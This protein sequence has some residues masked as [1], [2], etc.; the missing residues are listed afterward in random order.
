MMDG[1]VLHVNHESGVAVHRPGRGASTIPR[2]RPADRGS[3]PRIG[4][5]HDWNRLLSWSLSLVVLVFVGR[6]QEVLPGLSNLPLG[7]IAV[8]LSLIGL[9]QLGYLR[10]AGRI[11][12][13]TQ[14]RTMVSF[15]GI[16]AFTVPFALWPGGA[17]L[18][19]VA[20]L[21][22]SV[23]FVLIVI[24][25]RRPKHLM[26]LTLVFAVAVAILASAYVVDW[27][28]GGGSLTE[29]DL[30]AFDRND[31]ALLAVMGIPFALAI[32]VRRRAWTWVGFALAGYLSLAVVAT[33]SRGGF[34]AL[35]AT[36]LVMI[37]HGRFLSP[38]KKT[39]LIAVGVVALMIGGS[40]EYWDRI[41]AVFTSPS[42]DYNF[43][44]TDGRIEIW[45]RGVGYFLDDPITGVGIGNFPIAEG[46]TFKDADKGFKHWSAAHS[47][48][49]LVAAELGIGGLVLYLA[50]LWGIWRQGARTERIA[51]RIRAGPSRELAAIAEATRYSTVGFVIGAAF[52]SVTYSV[53]FVFLVATG[54]SLGLLGAEQRVLRPSGRALSPERNGNGARHR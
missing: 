2:L 3:V 28:I 34:L 12:S 38:A 11:V 20:L 52:L 5:R 4:S 35:L 29:Q 47:A 43:S 44:S 9:I 51:R 25:V 22:T 13:T 17:F 6:V 53:S 41:E 54:V 23:L 36:G 39:T 33:D 49:I 15:V 8:L 14:G 16:A 48:Y 1:E 26:Q 31:V 18:S 10:D 50:L 46:E 45:K 32:T 30:V 24:A 27:L 37:V 40:S 21:K 42:S 19:F 7:N